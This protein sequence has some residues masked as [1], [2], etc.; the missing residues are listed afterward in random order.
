[1][2]IW[3]KLAEIA[4]GG[5]I[6]LGVLVEWA[7]GLVGSGIGD[8]EVRRQVAFSVAL[9]A[10]AAKM[11]KADGVVSPTEVDA[12]RQQFTIPPGEEKHVARLFDLAKSDVAGFEIYAKR[13]AAFYGE[14]RRG[15]E[16]VLDGLFVIAAADGAVHEAEL[17]Y[18]QRVGAL[19]GIEGKAF[20]R[21][22][23]RHMVAGESDPYLVLGADRDMDFDA[24]RRRY[25]ALVAENHPD[26]VIGRG[27]PE[28]FVALANRRLAAIN[29]AWAQIELER[30]K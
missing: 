22:A 6:A 18:L 4:D 20:D 21:V 17:V 14:D 24:I 25:L 16:D 12:F 29:D 19:L 27:V 26:R 11:A 23:A 2:N 30:S 9:I 8:P 28:E 15:L 1:M 7:G 10:L 3:Q 5:V 13:V